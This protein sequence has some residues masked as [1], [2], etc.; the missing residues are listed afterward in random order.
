MLAQLSN[1]K[2][3][4]QSNHK[5]LLAS[6]SPRRKEILASVLGG[7]E[8]LFD[9]VVSTFEE[10]LPHSAFKTPGEY[11]LATARGKAL[12][13]ART[14]AA[15]RGV[16]VI[17]AADTVVFRGGEILEKPS[18]ASD[19]RR[20]LK[21]LSNSK[22]SVHT[23]VVVVVQAADEAPVERVA[24]ASETLVEF[25]PLE[26]AL[27]DAYVATGEPMGKAGSYAIQGL[28]RVLVRQVQGC[29][30]NIVGFP[31]AEFAQHFAT[32]V[33]ELR[34][35]EEEQRQQQPHK[36]AKVRV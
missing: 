23:G 7:D 20:M 29:F 26:D 27:I 2:G 34:E 8:S 19:A 33:A 16:F 35:E 22:H 18:D 9:I 24:F 15:K 1:L 21:S 12:D 28:G 13:I 10:N 4:L 36:R 25:Q 14:H 3:L 32:L 11:A 17:V 30:F 31:A 6:A 5:L